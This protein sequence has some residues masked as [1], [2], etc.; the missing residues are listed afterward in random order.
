RT[1]QF[2]RNSLHGSQN[3]TIRPARRQNWYSS[4]K[5]ITLSGTTSRGSTRR[6]SAPPLF[7]S[8]SQIRVEPARNSQQSASYR[9]H[10]NCGRARNSS[11]SGPKIGATRVSWRA[12]QMVGNKNKRRKKIVS[13]LLGL[14]GGIYRLSKNRSTTYSSACQTG[15]SACSRVQYLVCAL[16]AQ[17][18]KRPWR[19]SAPSSSQSL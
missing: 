19:R 3:S 7:S 17:P 9:L 6:W 18:Q 8:A 16:F 4:I 1:K 2:C 13:A 14:E 11:F 12:A 15:L 10:Q 5:L